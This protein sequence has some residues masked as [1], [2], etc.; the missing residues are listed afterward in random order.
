MKE[1]DSPGT[2]VYPGICYNVSG[3]KGGVWMP[4]VRKYPFKIIVLAFCIVFLKLPELSFAGEAMK[5]G[6]T[7]TAIGTMTGA[8]IGMLSSSEDVTDRKRLEDKRRHT[9]KMEAV[10]RLAGGVAHDFRS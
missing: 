6:G 3:L 9:Q 4:S 7:G 2:I 5:I 10:G 8:V 1:I